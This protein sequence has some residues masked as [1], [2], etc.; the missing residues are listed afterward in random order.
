MN[1]EQV[2]TLIRTHL[3]DKSRWIPD[4]IQEWTRF[5]ED[6]EAESLDL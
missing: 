1:H 6:L 4:G 2:F 3:A 5:R